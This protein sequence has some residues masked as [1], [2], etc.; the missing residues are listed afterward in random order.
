M[1][2]EKLTQEEKDWLSD[3]VYYQRE[4]DDMGRFVSFDNVKLNRLD[5][6][7][8]ELRF[9]YILANQLLRDYMD[10]NYE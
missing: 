3:C 9:R 7:L 8:Y 6:F 5:P 1:K 2:K 4:K 10:K